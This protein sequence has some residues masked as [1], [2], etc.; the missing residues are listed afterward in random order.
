LLWFEALLI[1]TIKRIK[2]KIL[3]MRNNKLA[4][5][6]VLSMAF[7]VANVCAMPSDSASTHSAS[8]ST[9]SMGNDED[10]FVFAGQC[11]NGQT[12][13]LFSYQTDVNG[14]TEYFYD[15]EGPVGKGTVKTKATPKT[16]AVRICRALAEI[17][18]D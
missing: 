11:P 1:L 6:T 13:R 7:W 8:A 16:M 12:Y 5:T 15:Y 4:W 9:K 2:F 3:P 14:V 18:N 17:A 10:S